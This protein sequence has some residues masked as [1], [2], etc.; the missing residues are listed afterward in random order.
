[1]DNKT[2]D[3]LFDNLR[4]LLICLKRETQ[5]IYIHCDPNAIDDCWNE[6][7]KTIILLEEYKQE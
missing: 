5:P 6:V 1:L 4:Q 7:F 3:L 2:I